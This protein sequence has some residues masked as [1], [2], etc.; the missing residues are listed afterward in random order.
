M[1]GRYI[2]IGISRYHHYNQ[3]T[4]AVTDVRRVA[5]ELARRGMTA[6]VMEDPTDAEYRS[7]FRTRLGDLSDG[8]IIYWAGHA[9]NDGAA[10]GLIT[11][12]TPGGDPDRNAMTDPATLLDAALRADARQILVILDTCYAGSD[13]VRL[14]QLAQ[15][16]EEARAAV[17][18]KRIWVGLLASAQSYERAVDGKF[19]S[20]LLRLLSEGPSTVEHQRRWSAHN[21]KISGE[22]LIRALCAE[23]PPDDAQEPQTASYGI[24]EPLLL[25]S[26]YSRSA[27]ERF[28]EDVLY[29]AAQGLEP[30]EDGWFFRGRRQSVAQIVNWLRACEPGLLVVTGPAGCGKSA[31]IGHVVSLADPARRAAMPSCQ[32]P[33]PDEPDLAGIEIN[34]VVHARGQSLS[35]LLTL[36]A[37]GLGAG[38]A[39]SVHGVLDRVIA[40]S[41]PPVVVIDALDEVR[42][43]ALR[44]V[45][46]K[47]LEPL[48]RHALILVG[49]RDRTIDGGT[50]LLSLLKPYASVHDLALASDG[51]TDLADY[52]TA[53][54]TDTGNTEV[55]LITSEIAERATRTDGGFLYARMVTSQLRSRP[56][57]TTVPGWREQ[58]ADSV[59]A[60]FEKDLVTAAR[61]PP[62]GQDAAAAA[63]AARHLLSALAWSFGRGLPTRELWPE[64]AAAIGGEGT[65]YTGD[66]ID[67]LLSNFGRYLVESG[68]EGQAVY[69][70]FHQELV[71]HLAADPDDGGR[72]DLAV[73][74]LLF[75]NSG[76]GPS[77][78]EPDGGP[79]HGTGIALGAD[80][81]NPYLELYAVAHLARQ[82]TD[83]IPLLEELADSTPDAYRPLLAGVLHDLSLRLT[84]QADPDGALPLAERAVEIRRQLATD[85]P[86]VY[87]GDLTVSLDNVR[88][89]LRALGRE[90]EA[91]DRLCTVIQSF[92]EPASRAFLLIWRCRTL[93]GRALPARFTDAMEALR[94]LTG[95][96]GERYEATLS[97]T[98]TTLRQL[99]EEGPEQ[100]EVLW[101]REIG[102][103][104]DW[105]ADARLL[106]V[107]K[108]WITIPGPGRSKAYAAAH[109][110]I[111][112]ERAASLLTQVLASYSE[113]VAVEPY[114]RLLQLI[115]EHG[116]DEAYRQV[117]AEETAR[118]WVLLAPDWDASSAYLRSHRSALVS[119]TCQEFLAA[120]ATSEPDDP[121]PVVHLGLLTLTRHNEVGRGYA[122]LHETDPGRH[123]VI[124]AGVSPHTD[125][126]V[127]ATLRDLAK[128]AQAGTF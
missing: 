77:G 85:H 128:A 122:V 44:P 27:P 93:H 1:T 83:A 22:D 10:F 94:L 101:T 87:L 119:P 36:I 88:H 23:W 108:T 25:N 127:L 50:R 52:V 58:L 3:L 42:S 32:G 35:S 78:A 118:S 106:T 41:V 107:L 89:L 38:G 62:P 47:L 31:V 74:R 54:L 28:V 99:Y 12:D 90:L 110:E 84:E 121:R 86:D 104:P 61:T 45:V 72:A 123:E 96:D 14:A 75:D 48:R 100:F 6:E 103:M 2:G 69:R 112:G 29:P 98:R 113:T 43:G 39:A 82:G 60:V 64:L 8:V 34:L 33:A 46:E 11:R 68:E 81:V 66:D 117:E 76:P 91:D 116:V 26:R 70:L 30:G 126:E 55:A 53:R 95:P 37:E 7:T 109:P 120:L 111:A 16:F 21:S 49:T 13:I 20:A 97:L 5:G 114:R 115:R 124:L 65:R 18:G 51:A 63:A 92:D 40:L 57:D 71:E 15:R 19:A 125:P 17:G 105:L 4:R 9:R 102:S 24:S 79:P 73:G 67:W 56:V 80:F 59:P